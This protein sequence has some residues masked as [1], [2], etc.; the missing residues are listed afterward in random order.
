MSQVFVGYYIREEDKMLFNVLVVADT[1]KQGYEKY[2]KF[3]EEALLNGYDPEE[4]KFKML[5]IEKFLYREDLEELD[6]DILEMIACSDY[7]GIYADGEIGDEEDELWNEVM[8]EDFDEEYI[9][10]DFEDEE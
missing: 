2:K 8:S 1:R 9:D 4:A 3:H 5:P 7:A 10:E 6:R